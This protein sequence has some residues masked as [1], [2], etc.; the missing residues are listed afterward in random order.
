MYK[1][2]YI[3]IYKYISWGSIPRWRGQCDDKSLQQ[4]TDIREGVFSSE[5]EEEERQQDEAVHK[6]TRQDRDEVHAQF[7][8]QVSRVMH[9]QNFS[10]HEEHNSKRKIPAQ[11]RTEAEVTLGEL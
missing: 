8:S 7:L 5:E 10:G 1:N 11:R 4:T 2:T 9:V 3:Y 6:Q